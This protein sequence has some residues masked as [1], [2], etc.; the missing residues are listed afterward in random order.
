MYK[1]LEEVVFYGMY[2]LFFVFM[3]FPSIKK[4]VLVS[5]EIKKL[6][7]LKEIT[8]NEL[9]LFET[10]AKQKSLL[11]DFFVALFISI[12]L[13]CF[14]GFYFVFEILPKFTI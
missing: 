7:Q 4:L 5:L 14:S 9:N 2:F 10:K 3:V 13:L 6:R 8:N 1:V 12:C 11:F